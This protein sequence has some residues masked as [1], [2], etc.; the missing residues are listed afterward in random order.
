MI[1]YL[2]VFLFYFSNSLTSK[3]EIVYSIEYL[4]EKKIKFESILILLIIL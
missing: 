2:I 3:E 4:I 1:S